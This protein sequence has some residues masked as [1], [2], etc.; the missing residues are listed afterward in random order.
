MPQ[1]LKDA[2]N[3]LPRYEIFM[4]GA[5][6]ESAKGRFFMISDVVKLLGEPDASTDAAANSQPANS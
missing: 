6:K 5:V 4:D 2:I 1:D 3:T